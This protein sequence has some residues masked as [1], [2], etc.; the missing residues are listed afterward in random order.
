MSAPDLES[1]RWGD[2]FGDGDMAASAGDR[3]DPPRAHHQV[4][5][6]ILQEHPLTDETAKQHQ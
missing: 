5:R 1:G 4:P 6:R 3:I 2:A